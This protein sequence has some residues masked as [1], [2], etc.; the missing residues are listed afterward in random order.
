MKTFL[1]GAAVVLLLGTLAPFI[2]TNNKWVRVL[3]FPRTQ[4]ALL[5]LVT[6]VC[7]LFVLQPANTVDLALIAVLLAALG[8][9]VYRVIPYTPIAPLQVRWTNKSDLRSCFSLIVANVLMKNRDSEALLHVLRDADPDLVLLVETDDWWDTA[10]RALEASYPHALRQPQSNEYGLI[11]YSKLSLEEA[12]IEFLVEDT[13]PSIHA[14]PRLPSGD[15]FAFYGV[16]P[17]PPPLSHTAERDA[18]LLVVGRR[19]KASPLPAVVAGDL[20]DVGWSATS[21]LFRR[22]SGLLDPRAGRGLYASYHAGYPFLRWP[23]DHVFHDPRFTVKEI[24]R[25][26]P[27]GSDHFP[28]FV[29]LCLSHAVAEQQA[30]RNANPAEEAEATR[31]IDEGMGEDGISNEPVDRRCAYGV[32]TR[33]R[34]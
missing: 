26:K 34:R 6:L 19:A 31:K 18:E 20:N 14:Q 33:E 13:V 16:H 23:L 30:P 4:L 21:R 1:V 5:L 29:R 25:L 10:T 17:A 8:W 32:A 27:F 28:I 15:S 11:L 2:P 12:S 7:F 22:I 24:R 9:Q 3:D